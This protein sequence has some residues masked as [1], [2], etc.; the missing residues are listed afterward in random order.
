MHVGCGDHK[1]IQCLDVHKGTK[2]Y[3]MELFPEERTIFYSMP[4]CIPQHVFIS[5]ILPFL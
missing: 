4:T 5:N 1:L 3:A 2:K